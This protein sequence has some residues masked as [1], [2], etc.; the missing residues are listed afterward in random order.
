MLL[1]VE[2]TTDLAQLIE[3]L[4]AMSIPEIER[5]IVKLLD[6]KNHL[7]SEMERIER[8]TARY[9]TL[10]RLAL[11]TTKVISDVVSQLRRTDS[12]Q[13]ASAFEVPVTSSEDMSRTAT[14]VP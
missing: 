12:Q 3:K 7:Q 2:T 13:K 10:A 5:M 14:N 9:A 1:T 6:V 4:G 8:E 11:D